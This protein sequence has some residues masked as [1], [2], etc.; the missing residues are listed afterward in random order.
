MIK[1]L[2]VFFYLLVIAFFVTIS[3]KIYFSD[4]NKKKS[5]RTINKLDL[6]IENYSKN[7]NILKNDTNNIIEYSSGDKNKKT[8]KY[9]FWNLLKKND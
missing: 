9:Y 8:K 2:K 3:I 7:L 1:E 5:Y 6:K 4:N